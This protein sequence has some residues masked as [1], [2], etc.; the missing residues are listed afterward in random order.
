MDSAA[1]PVEC[2]ADSAEEFALLCDVVDHLADDGP[3]RIYADWLEERGDERGIF[4]REFLATY[5][6]GSELPP[7]A[8]VPADWADLTGLKIIERI[9]VAGIREFR[10]EVLSF[11][12]PALRLDVD[13][14]DFDN[15]LP[16]ARRD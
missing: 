9:A 2:V 1:G 12:R 6:A 7:L 3:R 16:A 10:D 13:E 8:D 14:P 15:P 5:D 11:A 4:L